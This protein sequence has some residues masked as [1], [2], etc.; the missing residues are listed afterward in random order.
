MKANE[1]KSKEAIMK[2]LACLGHLIRGSLVRTHRKCGK[3]NCACAQGR[4]LHPVCL[5]STPVKGG[6]NKMTYVRKV[7]EEAVEAEL[8]APAVQRAS[9]RP[10]A[11]PRGLFKLRVGHIGA[12]LERPQADAHQPRCPLRPAVQ[13]QRQRVAHHRPAHDLLRFIVNI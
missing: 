10:A 9:P 13:L 12:G 2:E 8:W 7:E 11:L 5:L 3:P 6:G 1:R 4:H